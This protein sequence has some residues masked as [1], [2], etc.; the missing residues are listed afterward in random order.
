MGAVGINGD[1][2]ATCGMMGD[3]SD[4]R[5][6]QIAGAAFGVL[7][8]VGLVMPGAYIVESAGPA[9][10]VS[11]EF[12]GVNLLSIKG[13]ETYDSDTSF[14]MTTVSAAGTSDFGVTGAQALFS[15]LSTEQQ[16]IPVRAMYSK[17]ESAADVDERNAA[18]MSSSQDSGTVAGL[19]AAGYTVPMTLT[20]TG[21]AEDTSAADVF[22]A[23]DVVRTITVG[24]TT[25]D[26]TTFSDL[27]GVL[28]TIDPG[29]TVTIGVDRDGTEES[30]SVTTIAYEPDS[31]GWT[32]AGSQLGIYLE[33]SDIEFPVDVTYGI[34]NIG[35]PSAGS[36][37][38]LAIYDKLTD[39]S[40]GGDNKIAG[41]GTMSFSGEIGAIGGI[42]HK[43][44]GAASQ[45]AEYFLAPAVNCGEVV[46]H[47]PSGMQVF[48]VRTL[49]ESISTVK[50]IAAGD[51]S[52]LTT[53][54]MVM[55]DSGTS[56]AS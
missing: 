18:Q 52:Q 22:K 28:G 10:D 44:R 6:V 20:V 37:F 39:G 29:T 21:A 32:H 42:Q 17:S 30:L 11:G 19:E 56:S 45:G 33:T 14:Y 35:G 2:L 38:A 49:D 41:T 4:R 25:T 13:T 34:E 8:A 53:C 24:S 36:M 26:V 3:V 5:R 7:V 47:E 48:A 50:A 40:L 43:M 12:N 46:G 1:F 31:T 54:E 9:L 27:S 15:I 55:E 23:G 16:L 51:T